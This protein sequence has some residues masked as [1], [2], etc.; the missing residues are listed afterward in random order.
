[1]TAIVPLCNGG[2]GGRFPHCGTGY[3]HAAHSCARVPFLAGDWMQFD[4]R[5]ATV[6]RNTAHSEPGARTQYRQLLDLL[7]S[8]PPAAAS[9]LVEAAYDRLGQLAEALPQAVQS[10]IL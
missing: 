10:A 3:G 1:M 7:G 9:E 6:L 4:D 8:M 5:L 2:S